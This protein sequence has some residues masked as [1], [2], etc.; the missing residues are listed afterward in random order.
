MTPEK[1]KKAEKYSEIPAWACE[2]CETYEGVDAKEVTMYGGVHSRLCIKCHNDWSRV[3]DLPEWDRIG[4]IETET[5]A[6]LAMCEQPHA[7]Y[8]KDLEKLRVQREQLKKFFR[9]YARKF[10][11]ELK[12]SA[13]SKK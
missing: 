5:T 9:E 12:E 6:L 7:D 8:R 4:Q 1:T 13:E 10:L 11:L 3:L 2:R